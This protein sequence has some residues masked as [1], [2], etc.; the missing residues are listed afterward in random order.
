MS[1]RTARIYNLRTEEAIGKIPGSGREDPYVYLEV[2][3]AQCRCPCWCTCQVHGICARKCQGPNALAGDLLRVMQP[4]LQDRVRHDID[5]AGHAG[6]HVPRR[7]VQKLPTRLGTV[8]SRLPRIRPEIVRFGVAE[9]ETLRGDSPRA[10][11]GARSPA[12]LSPERSSGRGLRRP[13][14]RGGSSGRGLRRPLSPGRSSGR[15]PRRPLRRSS[16]RG[17]PARDP[18]TRCAASPA[19]PRIS[20]YRCGR[21]C[22]AC[23]ARWPCALRRS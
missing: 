2:P 3:G 12:A 9:T 23:A 19:G 17:P 8:P 21:S 13:F 5:A 20:R 18:A 6:S 14:P 22:R 1:Q 7:A 10:L 4:A 15:G 16:A 11:F